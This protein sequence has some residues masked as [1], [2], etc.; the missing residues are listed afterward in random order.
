MSIIFSYDPGWVNHG[1][2]LLEYDSD[3][4]KILKSKSLKFE[5]KDEAFKLFQIHQ[6][7]DK[8]F[9]KYQ[10]DI[11]VYEKPVIQKGDIQSKLSKTLGVI[12]LSAYT[13]KIPIVFYSPNEIK[14]CICGEGRAK[15]DEIQKN[16]NRLL[17]VHRK[18]DKDHESDAI[19]IGL[20][21][22]GKEIN[23][24]FLSVI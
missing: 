16:V 17:K 14:K 5:E 2:S 3:N 4:I 9:K 21:Y 1:V 8:I 13:Q 23:K 6:K 7:F 15:K 11:F 12:I 22:Y 19:A 20:T 18:Y 10:P 24:N